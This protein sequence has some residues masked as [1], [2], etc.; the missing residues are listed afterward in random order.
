MQFYHSKLL[1]SATSVTHT[2]T[3]KDSGNIAFH[4]NDT[5]ENVHTN[6]LH[7]SQVLNYEVNSLI[8]M[9][10]I[11]SSLVHVVSDEDNYTNPKECDALITNKL[12]T[13]LM[14]MVAD[15]SPILI[16]DPLKKVIGVAHAGRQGA[17]KN[18]IKSTLFSMHDTF[19][20]NLVDILV[21]IG[22]SIQKCCYEVGEEIYKEAMELGL[23]YAIEVRENSYY[24]D[25]SS[26]LKNQLHELGI[27]ETNSEVSQVCTCCKNQTYNSYR[28]DSTTGR[29]AG[30]ILLK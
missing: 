25:I 9:K 21:S 12:N 3:T 16:Y 29:F 13:P 20:S 28:A 10:Q 11:H 5:L 8:H 17:F 14:V 30:V 2:F 6:H 1:S 24:L 18:I 19:D 4:V 23:D 15:C 26:I 7:L 27:K 22:P